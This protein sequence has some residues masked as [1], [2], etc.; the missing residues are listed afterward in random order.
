MIDLDLLQFKDQLRVRKEAD[1]HYIWDIVRLKWVVAIPEEWVRQL[2]IH[3][4]IHELGYR[5]RL[6]QVEKEIL[7]NGMRRRYDLLLYGK[8]MQPYLL[9]ECKAPGVEIT[10]ET[11]DQIARYNMSLQVPFLLVSNGIRQFCC[12]MDYVQQTY[13]FTTCI[14]GPHSA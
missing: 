12:K 5:S 14:P 3:F 7:V 1:T 10:Q 13:R 9:A 8:N 11:F 2:L 4:L 6:I